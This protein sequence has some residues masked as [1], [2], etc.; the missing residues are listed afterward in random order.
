[1]MTNTDLHHVLID[2]AD[3]FRECRKNAAQGSSAEVR[4]DV[5]VSAILDAD[6]LLKGPEDSIPLKPLAEWLAGYA[7]P[8]RNAMMQTLT[9]G[10]YINHESLTEAWVKVLEEIR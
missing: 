1:M 4:F 3:Y 8:P 5:Y 7:A 2:I 10:G 9:P 6:K